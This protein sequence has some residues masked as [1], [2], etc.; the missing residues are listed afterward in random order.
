MWEN[1]YKKVQQKNLSASATLVKAMQLFDNEATLIRIASDLGFGTGID[2][3]ALIENGWEVISIDKQAEAIEQLKNNIPEAYKS[4]LRII[5][6]SFE[7]VHL[8]QTLLVNASFSLPFCKPENYDLLWKKVVNSI[9]PGGRF[10]GHFF[11]VNDSWVIDPE[12]TF[13]T[14]EQVLNLFNGFE[15]EYFEEIEKDGKTLGG[16]EKHWHVFH[17]VAKMTGQFAL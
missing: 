10:A 2:T 3:I 11:G 17:V 13:H 12:K 5:N 14:K 9:L 7:D 16:K 4:K 1:H 8:P 15:M 6:A